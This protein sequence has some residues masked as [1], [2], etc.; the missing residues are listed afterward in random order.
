M[1]FFKRIVIEAHRRSIWQVLGLYLAVSWAVFEAT[2]EIT[3][4]MGLPDWVPGFAFV[5]LLIGLPIVLATTFIQEGA[6]GLRSPTRADPID[7]TLLPNL[8]SEPQPTPP[9]HELLFTWQ[10]A[11]VGGIVAFLL[12]GITAGGYMGLRNAGIGPFA[13]L[14]SSG[15][16]DAREPILIA[17][18]APLNG[19]TMLATTVTEAFR[20][21]FT[22]S[23]AVTVVEPKHVRE[24]LQRMSRDVKSRVDAELAHE[25]A[26]RDNIKTYLTGEVSQAGGK[27]V[28]AGKLV[29][30]TDGR[31]L[32]SYRETADGAD[33]IIGAV[34][35][36]SKKLREKIGESLKTIRAEK[37]L[38][39]V[40]TPSLEALQKYTQAA[41]AIDTER[42]WD[43][44]IS[45]LQ[46]AIELDSAFAM[47]WRKLSVAYVN[48]GRGRDLAV[49]AA[50]KAYD[51]RD[52]LTDAERY[53]ATAFYHYRVTQDYDKAINAYTMLEER[54]PRWPPNNLGLAYLQTREY[55]QAADAFSRSIEKDSS[56]AAGYGN[57]AEALMYLGDIKGAEQV[58][59]TAERFFPEAP[60]G[61]EYRALIAT[62]QF[63]YATAEK[64]LHKL[65]EMSRSSSVWRGR[66]NVDL[67]VTKLVR[68]QQSQGRRF[69]NEWV[70]AEFE[71]GNVWTPLENALWEVWLDIMT[72]RNPDRALATL[73]AALQKHPLD[74]IPALNRPY[75]DIAGYYGFLGQ[76]QRARNYQAQFEAA[77][78]AELRGNVAPAYARI[79]GAIAFSE[80]RFDDAIAAWRKA[81]EA[82]PCRI[83][84]DPALALAFEQAGMPDSAIARYHHYLATPETFRIWEDNSSLGPAYEHLA[85]LYVTQGNRQNAA[86]YAAKFTEL[87]HDADA[88]LQPRVQAKREL[89]RQLG[90]R[91]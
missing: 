39:A 4:R 28:V 38:E 8:P 53:H 71:R 56:L 32:A 51:F 5:L 31:V 64:E 36:L 89:L 18:F 26:V 23:S 44:G 57:L 54:D 16:L 15:E 3:E 72:R 33:D 66:A 13:S 35:L 37:P 84:G 29:A 68:G 30:T 52:R 20:V 60:E 25:I 62:M 42:N 83:C 45:L 2:A 79:A 74:S 7:P 19:D 12:L 46:E 65:L 87:W 49:R 48:S 43:T 34:D 80:K 61:S 47:A 86:L 88:E 9:K 27:Y 70:A 14:L 1:S 40:S 78:P 90:S 76:P 24:V 82:G 85:E 59:T 73:D 63:D 75:L 17:E 41:Y 11:I 77:V 22:Q 91:N 21:D 50:I 69:R 81:S 6:P 55:Q 10:K 58:L 67:A